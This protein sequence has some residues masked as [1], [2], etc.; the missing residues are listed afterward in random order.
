[1]TEVCQGTTYITEVE[2]ALRK[3]QERRLV[4]EGTALWKTRKE[5]LECQKH[6]EQHELQEMLENYA[7]WGKPG[8]GAPCE[9]TLRKKNFPLEPPKKEKNRHK[10]WGWMTKPPNM[11]IQNSKKPLTVTSM[12]KFYDTNAKKVIAPDPH[13]DHITERDSGK[14]YN[15]EV[16]VYR[17]NG[18]VELVP[19]LTRREHYSQS[20]PVRH[21]VSDATKS[22][23]TLETWRAIT[24]TNR[25]YIAELADQIQQKRERAM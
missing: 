15:E 5:E 14:A 2:E 25:E 7:P 6:R 23:Y 18:G 8:G 17:L 21:L 12:N 11:N 16:Q 3:E 9:T 1:M 4:Q 22:V 24:A 10:Q 13:L 20:H 19:L